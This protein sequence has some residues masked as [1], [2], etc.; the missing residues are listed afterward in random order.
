MPS[1]YPQPTRSLPMQLLLQ[2]DRPGEEREKESTDRFGFPLRSFA[3]P[4]GATWEE[5][6]AGRPPVCQGSPGPGQAHLPSSKAGGQTGAEDWA[7]GE[8]GPELMIWKLLKHLLKL[9]M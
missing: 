5:E 7:P 9:Q 3:W 1:G 8:T 6:E 2:K 4:A